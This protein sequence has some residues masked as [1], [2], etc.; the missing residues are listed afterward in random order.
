MNLFS[1]KLER[2][3]RKSGYGTGLAKKIA[4]VLE[5]DKA[6]TFNQ[7]VERVSPES[8]SQLAKLLA[9]LSAARL[10]DQIIRVESPETHSGIEDFNSIEQVPSTI[11]DV[12]TQKYIDVTP[13]NVIVLFRPSDVI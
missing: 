4:K 8:P 7:L 2:T 13:S 6:L 11:Y 12:Y 1:T 10:I 3:M 5:P 9:E